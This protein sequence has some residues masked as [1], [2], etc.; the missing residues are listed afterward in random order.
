MDRGITKEEIVGNSLKV[1]K[2]FQ[3]MVEEACESLNLVSAAIHVRLA[4]K[5][6]IKLEMI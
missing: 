5:A 6:D 4:K 1:H 2:L 3:A